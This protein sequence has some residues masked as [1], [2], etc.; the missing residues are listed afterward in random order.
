MIILHNI[1]LIL[2][3]MPTVMKSKIDIFMNNGSSNRWMQMTLESNTKIERAK[4]LV[5]IY[6]S[7]L[8]SWLIDDFFGKQKQQQ[9][10]HK[11]FNV[12]EINSSFRLFN[13]NN[14]NKYTHNMN[15]IQ[16]I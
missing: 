9:Q 11:Y 10:Q 3:L 12:I 7:R 5:I 13:N 6:V 4:N 2:D 15:K 1:V 8:C 14:N 16:S